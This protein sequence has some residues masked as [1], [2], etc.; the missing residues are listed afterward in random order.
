MFKIAFNW[1]ALVS[2]WLIGPAI[3]M[4]VTISMINFVLINLAFELGIIIGSAVV[5][6][7]NTC[8]RE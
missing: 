2:S 1:S 5:S 4:A 6:A 8:K 7:A 3:V